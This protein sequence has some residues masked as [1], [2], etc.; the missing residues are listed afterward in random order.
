MIGA[1][2]SPEA[3]YQLAMRLPL[4]QLQAILRGQPSEIDQPTALSVLKQKM[5]QKT[6][7][8]GLQAQQQLQQPSVKD[9]MLQQ[10]QMPEDMG[11][12]QAP[13]AQQAG[14]IPDGGVAGYA[15]GGDVRHFQTGGTQ[16][17]LFRTP[18]DPEISQ[19]KVIDATRQRIAQLSAQGV[20][21]TVAQQAVAAEA[22]GGPSAASSLSRFFPQVSGQSA[23]MA[24]L[25][26]LGSLGARALT[27]ATPLAGPAAVGLTSYG[28]AE[29]VMR[30][31]GVTQSVTDYLANLT[32]LADRE[33][34]ALADKPVQRR[35]TV[36]PG[37]RSKNYV[38][39]RLKEVDTKALEPVPKQTTRSARQQEQA[40]VQMEANPASTPDALD[41]MT[42]K[43][44]NTEAAPAA[45][46]TT[47]ASTAERAAP[48]D[49]GYESAMRK[50]SG[51]TQLYMDR[52]SALL[53]TMT[54]T[55]EE[56]E[57][58]SAER[59]G[60]MALKAAQALLQSG[61][62]SGAARGSAL[63]QIAELTQAYGK[64]DREDKKAMIGAEIN[65]LGAQAQLAQGNSKM[66]VDMFQHAEKLASE[67]TRLEADKLFR[68]REL[69]LKEKGLW[70]EKT[71][72]EELIKLKKYIADGEAAWRRQHINVLAGQG[73]RDDLRHD[74]AM[75][76]N[77]VAE[78]GQN[79][80]SMLESI[81]IQ[82]ADISLPQ[83]QRA[84]LRERATAIEAAL[85]EREGIK[86]LA[87]PSIQIPDSKVD[88]RNIIN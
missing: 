25:R 77:R 29:P 73:R 75:E 35:A 6:A 33:K 85:A 88:P 19:Q 26:G 71:Q 16:G 31:T 53:K 84:Q 15:E 66:A 3:Q 14:T 57:S 86:T 52:M 78:S 18:F 23:T 72:G 67:A 7:M 34:E 43:A 68:Q 12:A 61:T 13:G 54:P 74:A 82:M 38:D 1:M 11:I 22:A 21:P 62:T 44:A 64:E 49:T 17:E 39:P 8:Q 50:I 70:N 42:D 32:G 55:A 28:L 79:L 69:D 5:Q 20:P 83:A 45:G 9:R 10:S 48:A 40:P 63:G 41:F 56:K 46:I 80:R 87:A 65:M 37:Y 24:G 36:E 47:L 58:R 59:K 51:S 4:E 30:A 60:V 2:K 81:K 27:A 76:R